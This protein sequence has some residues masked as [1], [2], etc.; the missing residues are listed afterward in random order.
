MPALPVAVGMYLGLGTATPIF[1][2]VKDHSRVF[3]NNLRMYW[4]SGRPIGVRTFQ[5]ETRMATEAVVQKEIV[6]D[7]ERNRVAWIILDDLG[8]G[9]EVYVNADYRGSDLLDRY[10]ADHFAQQAE[11]GPYVVLTRRS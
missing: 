11:F 7:L 5:L 2:G 10:I 9:D 6:A 8:D 1:V 3:W 4:L